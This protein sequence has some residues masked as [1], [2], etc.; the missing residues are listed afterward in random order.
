MLLVQY[1]RMIIL[2]TFAQNG[3]S[4]AR[5]AEALGVSRQHLWDRVLK[6]KIDRNVLP[7]THTGRPRRKF[8]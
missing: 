3:F 7:R 5:T 8:S 4:R 2:Q 1:E 6:L